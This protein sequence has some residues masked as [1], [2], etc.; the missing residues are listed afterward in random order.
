MIPVHFV[1]IVKW[2]L[3]RTPW[4]SSLYKKFTKIGFSGFLLG[5]PPSPHC[6][7]TTVWRIVKT[8]FQENWD[9]GLFIGKSRKNSGSGER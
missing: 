8:I 6:C 4:L 9:F 1:F 7:G 2:L 3:N 5:N